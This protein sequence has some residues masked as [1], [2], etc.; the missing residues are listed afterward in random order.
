MLT[1]PLA[2]S[3]DTA[4]ALQLVPL[5]MLALLYARRLRTLAD[6]AQR[7]PRW[8]ASCFYGG[9]L[10]IAIALIA[11]G[12]VSR[13]RL[14]LL[15]LENLL[16]GDIAALL[17]VLGLT[18][19]LLRPLLRVGV[20]ARLRAL[21]HPLVAF[22]LWAIDLYAWHL[23]VFF[24]A[25]L[26]HPG[27]QALEHATLFIFGLNMWMCLFGPLAS[28]PWFGD[29]AKLG[30]ILAVRVAGAVLGNILLWSGTLFYSYYLAG[31]AHFHLSPLADQNIAGAVM[32][33]EQAIVTIGLFC[34]LFLRTSRENVSVS[35]RLRLAGSSTPRR[36]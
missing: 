6:G 3:I 11:L 2:V 27:I 15:M 1:V 19:A 26:R 30:Y 36:R 9:L 20:F 18:R 5:A 29:R 25:A 33:G 21:S 34:W 31:D 24:E 7:V 28:P 10:V 35:L 8:R 16:I 17:I 22:V 23:A 32:L 14:F 12:H 4:V 13:E